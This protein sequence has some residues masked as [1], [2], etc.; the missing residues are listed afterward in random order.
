VFQY[1]NYLYSPSK[2]KSISHLDETAISHAISSSY[3]NLPLC[4]VIVRYR[5]PVFFAALWIAIEVSFH[6][7]S[8]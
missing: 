2:A 8:R 4:L 7:Y 5:L 6:A 3:S 1:F